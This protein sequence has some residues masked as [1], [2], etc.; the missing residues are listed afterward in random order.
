M[1]PSNS[2]AGPVIP[3]RGQERGEDAV[4]CRVGERAAL[5]HRQLAGRVSRRAVP[6]VPAIPRAW[7]VWAWS[8]AQQLRR[9]QQVD[10][11]EP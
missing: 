8:R 9:G 2:G 4:A 6:V 1:S 7:T 11:S 10:E 5:P 3:S